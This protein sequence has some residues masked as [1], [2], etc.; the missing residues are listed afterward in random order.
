MLFFEELQRTICVDILEELSSY[1]YYV[2][3]PRPLACYATN[4][5][6]RSVQGGTP[7]PWEWSALYAI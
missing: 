6:F 3:K 5:T 4:V 7:V 1:N 2:W